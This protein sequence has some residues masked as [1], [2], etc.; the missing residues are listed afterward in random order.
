MN[1]R[2]A[3]WLFAVIALFQ[4][5]PIW[6]VR[7]IPTGDGPEHLYNSLVIHDLVA[8]RKG[9]LTDVYAI[10]RRPLPNWIGHAA[11]AGLMFV[12]PPL[13]AEKLFLS[14]TILLFLGAAWMLASAASS[15][16][17]A[18]LAFPFTYHAM[19]QAGFYNFSA[20]AGLCIAAIA[21]WWCRR[22]RPDAKTIAL[23]AVLLVLCYFSHPLPFAIAC[24]SI[25]ILWIFTVRGRTFAT[26][27]RHLLAFV[28]VA[29]LA[30]WYALGQG[31]GTVA[32]HKPIARSLADLAQ[33]RILLTFSAHQLQLGLFVVA[34]ITVLALISTFKERRAENAFL[35]ILLLLFVLSLWA[36]ETIA[37]GQ[38]FAERVALLLY[39]LPIAWLSPRVP[40][41]A[42]I[43]VVIVFSTIAIANAAFIATR[44]RH[45]ERPMR[46]YVESVKAAAP[47]SRMLPLMFDR[48]AEGAFVPLLWHAAAYGAAER[49][50]VE[51]DNYEAHTAYFP[52][53]LRDPASAFDFGVAEV[54]P[55]TLDV[56]GT[57]P[58][59][60]YIATW[61][62]PANSSIAAELDRIYRVVDAR[63]NARL[64]ER[65]SAFGIETIGSLEQV[66]LPM[67]GT[68]G[69]VGGVLARWRID[70]SVSNHGRETVHVALSHCTGMPA[71]D[72][73]VRP[74]ETVPIAANDPVRPFTYAYVPH[75]WQ[76]SITFS[77]V[78]HRTDR[79]MPEADV[80]V[81]AVPVREFE[82][83]RVT[84]PSVPFA[85]GTRLNLRLYTI[86]RTPPSA[87]A[88]VIAADGSTLGTTTLPVY[89]TNYYPDGDFQNRFPGLG[90]R[91]NVVIETDAHVWAFITTSDRDGRST[92][93]LPR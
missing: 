57:A 88:R 13:I 52:T 19:L 39:V 9:A 10:D 89:A 49:R 83:K 43:A 27:V 91:L 84:I 90:G 71:C 40:K 48:S 72:F 69:E 87:T 78:A 21:V 28:P 42:Q 30:I 46:D 63:G 45:Y 80:N 68:T 4:L 74:G 17:Y 81:P 53:T 62:L 32:S 85:P 93:L 54:A 26:H 37:G 34:S 3:A 61:K 64:Y 24:A 14:A 8:R 58:F 60:R 82:S 77:T 59:A 51:L 47:Q 67:A 79:W 11:M 92:V 6:S 65:R 36:P 22:D 5:V 29:P 16:A 1:A 2:A 44:W 12:V 41:A 38:M 31:A 7:Y 23:V 76:R 33:A 73:D 35:P 50:L 70:Q 55:Q 56:A 15:R 20:A 86:G 25:G 18:F 66:L 75:R